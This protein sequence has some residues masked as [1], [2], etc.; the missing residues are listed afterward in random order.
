MTLAEPASPIA[1]TDI[2]QAFDGALRRGDHET[3]ET[4]LKQGIQSDPD[5]ATVRRLLAQLLN[6]Q[7]RRF[8]ASEHV[9]HLIRLRVI[10]P[11]ELLS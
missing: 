10:L 2:P 1:V 8:E 11:H 3:A 7:G 9:L 5:D 6:A 4:I